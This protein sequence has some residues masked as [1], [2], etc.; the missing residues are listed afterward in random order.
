MKFWPR[1]LVMLVVTE[2]TLM[3]IGGGLDLHGMAFAGGYI[4]V[5]CTVPLI[6][7]IAALHGLQL[8][9]GRVGTALTL[10][11]GL[12]PTL[13]ALI[14]GPAM[15]VKGTFTGYG[16]LLTVVGLPWCAAWLLTSPSRDAVEHSANQ[17]F[18]AD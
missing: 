14:I 15:G 8:A 10:L 3:V 16:L 6:A 9:F 2:L 1:I 13:F 17:M 4:V 12:A 7:I 18:G 5:I 11:F